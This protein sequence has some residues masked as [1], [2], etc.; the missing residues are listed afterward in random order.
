MNDTINKAIDEAISNIT[1]SGDIGYCEGV[2]GAIR[3]DIEVCADGY[4]WYPDAETTQN[5]TKDSWVVAAL[6]KDGRICLVDGGGDWELVEGDN[7]GAQGIST[8]QDLVPV[9]PEGDKYEYQRDYLHDYIADAK[10]VWLNDI[11][12]R[13]AKEDYEPYVEVDEE[14]SDAASKAYNEDDE[15]STLYILD[16]IE[17]VVDI[18]GRL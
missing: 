16:H 7:V 11:L 9:M 13:L 2:D 3:D 14:L 17:D 4:A 10:R 12:E 5:F 18:L 15:E 6:M 8:L 1:T